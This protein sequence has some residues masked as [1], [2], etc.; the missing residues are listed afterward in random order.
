M[1]KILLTTFMTFFLTFSY[2]QASQE[3]MG[4]NNGCLDGKATAYSPTYMNTLNSILY[5]SAISNEY[6]DA[7]Q[8]YFYKCREE[9]L[10]GEPI[11]GGLTNFIKCNLFNDENACKKNN[12]KVG[13]SEQEQ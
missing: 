7:Y 5:N 4:A 9:E 12:K 1:K 13:S 6:K 11:S 8:E 3:A 2:S 10:R